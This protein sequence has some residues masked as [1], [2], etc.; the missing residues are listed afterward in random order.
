MHSQWLVISNRQSECILDP[1]LRFFRLLPLGTR[2]EKRRGS[3]FD[4]PAMES[5]P[6][7]QGFSGQTS[8]DLPAMGILLKAVPDEAI[9]KAL[10]RRWRRRFSR[11][12]R[13]EW[14]TTALFRSLA[15]AYQA[16]ALPTKNSSTIFD[17]GT[18]IAVWV[19]AFETLQEGRK[20]D[21]T[22]S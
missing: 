10:Q 18:T 4:R 22:E 15:V 5:V 2:T 11:G 12:G 7:A 20:N 19:S 6:K 21:S 17:Y 14:H 13:K 16:C 3:R 8:P 9:L 1:V